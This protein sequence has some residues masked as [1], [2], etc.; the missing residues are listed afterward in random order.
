VSDTAKQLQQKVVEGS[1]EL[2]KLL[3]TSS[4]MSRLSLFS[5]MSY[6]RTGEGNAEA[7]DEE[8]AGTAAPAISAAD[9]QHAHHILTASNTAGSGPQQQQQQQQLGT[10][11]EGDREVE[12]SA[13]SVREAQVASPTG[14]VGKG[15]AVTLERAHSRERLTAGKVPKGPPMM[16]RSA[17]LQV[18]V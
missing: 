13:G 17:Y 8:T 12:S 1:E 5:N 7:A 18:R 3:R 9:L 11:L 15:P 4:S 10:V 14:E 16:S 2:R 6:A